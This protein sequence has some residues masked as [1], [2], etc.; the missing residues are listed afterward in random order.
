[1]ERARI[2][3]L[4]R[5]EPGRFQSSC[6]AKPRLRPAATSPLTTRAATRNASTP[7]PDENFERKVRPRSRVSATRQI[8]TNKTL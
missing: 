4:V 2:P 1:V 7:H 5:R 6:A 8:R 3:V